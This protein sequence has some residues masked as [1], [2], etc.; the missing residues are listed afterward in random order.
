MLSDSI[1]TAE[2]NRV[3]HVV[4]KALYPDRCPGMVDTKVISATREI[5]HVLG[6]A[7]CCTYAAQAKVLSREEM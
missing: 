5:L 4:E 2:Y 7:I 3:Y 1:T 6:S